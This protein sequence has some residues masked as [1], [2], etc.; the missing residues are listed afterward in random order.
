MHGPGHRRPRRRLRR[1]Q[2]LR[3]AGPRARLRL[4]RHL[5][6]PGHHRHL[7]R[8]RCASPAAGGRPRARGT[9]SSAARC[10]ADGDARAA[11]LVDAEP[12]RQHPAGLGDAARGAHQARH[13]D[14]ARQRS[15]ASP[16]LYTKLR[17]DLRARGRLGAR[18]RGLQQPERDQERRATSSAPPA[19]S[20]TPSTGSTPTATTSPTSTRAT[21]RCAPAREPARTSRCAAR[22]PWQGFEPDL[23]RVPLRAVQPAPAGDQPV[24]P[25]PTG[26]T[27]RRA[28]SARP[29]TTSSYG[30][31]YRSELARRPGP[32]R[33]PRRAAR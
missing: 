1:R 30:S 20:A 3:A 6:R 25:R 17:V 13:R 14:R 4:E 7:R 23:Y 9:T 22:F 12:G 19:R 28:A 16:L 15:R 32:A 26:T 29:T 21:T 31:I 10:T 8:R 5:G 33:H 2:P 24:L 18:L 27:S 11:Q